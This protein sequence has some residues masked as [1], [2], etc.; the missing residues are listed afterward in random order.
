MQSTI[1]A[2]GIIEMCLYEEATL[3]EALHHSP[4]DFRAFKNTY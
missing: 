3:D 2:R 4:R 1:N